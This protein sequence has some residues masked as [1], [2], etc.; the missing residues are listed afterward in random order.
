ME[1]VTEEILNEVDIGALIV[2]TIN[3]LCQSL[4]SSI[5]NAIY[6][7]LDDLVFV[8]PN[9]T[10]TNYLERIFGTNS[11]TGLLVLSNS[12]VL[13]FILYY[14]IRR[15]ISFYA[16]NE[17]ESPYIFLIKGIF[18]TILMNFS[19]ELCSYLISF[20]YEI[21]NFITSLG[22]NIFGREI[23]FSSLI[24]IL[25]SSFTSGFNVFSLDGILSGMLSI[26]SFSLIISFAL[27]YIMIKVLILSAP[28]AFLCLLNKS[29]GGFFK[30]WYRSLIALLLV[31]ILIALIL[32]LPY[33]IIK[34]SSSDILNKILIIG[35][36]NAL[37]KSSQ[38]I[39]E[40][41]GGIGISSNF[42]SRYI[43]F[44][45]YV[46]EVNMSKFNF[47]LNY[48]YSE[49]LLGII[50]YKILLPLCIYAGFILLILSN[51]SLTFFNS[52]SIFTILFL[53]IFLLSINNINGEPIY[54]FIFA[55]VL[56]HTNS[57]VYLFKNDCKNSQ[58]TILLVHGVKKNEF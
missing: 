26:S 43:R 53:P 31:Q 10:E 13:A 30:S 42:Q 51:I 33:A 24:N 37:L 58:K 12:L 56:F 15:F 49:K 57:K 46:F 3:S 52:A 2:E 36:I 6:P 27:R 47:P 29:T 19:L 34:D 17:V 44:K 5:D 54:S 14:S 21:T 23:S 18:I 48:K 16:G 50:E 4:F 35:A 45:I 28:F 40:F 11:N 22:E 39:K 8:S 32:L 20:T 9:I 7:I 25:N 55:F 38:F 41:M 1:S